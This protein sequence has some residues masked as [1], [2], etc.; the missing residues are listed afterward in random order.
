MGAAGLLLAVGGVGGGTFGAEDGVDLEVGQLVGAHEGRCG[1]YSLLVP[2]LQL[3]R[4]GTQPMPIDAR[5]HREDR[6]VAALHAARAHTPA[7]VMGGCRVVRA[8]D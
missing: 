4:H 7:L 6:I 5:N 1:L 2:R 8:E 3:G